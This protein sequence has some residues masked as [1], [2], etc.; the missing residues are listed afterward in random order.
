MSGSDNSA[1]AIASRKR[2]LEL[3]KNDMLQVIDGMPA[4]LLVVDEQRRVRAI[5]STMSAMLGIPDDALAGLPSLESLIPAVELGERVTAALE[6]GAPQDAVVVPVDGHA[7]GVRWF[8][9]NIRRTSQ[10]G[11]VQLLLIGQDVTFRRQARQRLQESEEFFRLTFSQA[12]I[13]IALLSRE[14]R[15]LRVNRK[16]SQIVGFSEIELLQRFFHQVTHP[17]E[18]DEDKALMRRLVAGETR[19]ARRESRYLCKDGRTVW[20]ALS[21][22][23]MREAA[24]GQLRLIVAVQDISRR[25]EAEEALLRMATHDTL[26]GLPNR[27]LLQ[28]R[29]AQAI[30]HAQ[31]ARRQV[32]VMFIDLDR[33]KHVNDSLGHEAGDQLIVEIARRL[34][35]V[36]RESDTVARQGGDEFVV[37]LADLASSDDAALVAG[38]LLE[39]LFEPLSLVGHEVFPS[40]S[41]GIAMYPGDGRDSEALLKAADSAMY[42]AKASGGKRYDFYADEMAAEAQAHL[43]IEHGLQRGLLRGEFVLHYQPQVDA[44]SG[45]IVGV[46]AL[47]RWQ[48]EGG[49]M[50][51]PNDF[52]PLAEETGLI[53]PIGEWVLGEALRQQA[54]F[55]ALLGGA[56]PR[57]SVNMSARQFREQDVAGKVERLL[58]ETGCEPS[59]LTLEITESVLMENPSAAA[60]TMARLSS[61]G[62]H[63]AVDDFGTGYSS[64]ANLKRFPI[65]CLKIDRSFVSDIADGAGIDGDDAAIVKAVIALA[66][67]MKLE[68]IAEGVESAAQLDFLGA[69]GCKRMQGFYFSRPVTAE[70]VEELLKAQHC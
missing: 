16:L 67:S 17:D 10:S 41:I 48:P 54:R 30:A 68:V 64:L 11:G 38:K 43:R 46:E 56:P 18:L 69:H 70:A 35:A 20:V 19:D 61:M 1:D 28:D 40:G 42:R 31:R 51:P 63:L 57:M 37:V 52:I 53:V 15:F 65:H 14:G 23:T 6:T 39:S 26:T 58:Q 59:W 45:R 21:A 9:F 22:S 55:A 3:G 36:L 2:F 8:E 27:L 62:V 25:K 12:A 5:N 66:Q 13:G 33:F 60:A 47:V 44:V 24:S 29:L 4:G 50:V 7:D 32:G 49:A 34:S